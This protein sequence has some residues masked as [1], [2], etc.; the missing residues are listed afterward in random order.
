M[1]ETARAREAWS[2]YVALGPGRS[3]EALLE[4]YRSETGAGRSAPTVRLATLKDWSRHHG[5]QARLREMAEQQERAVREQDAAE[6][7][8]LLST[9]YA[10]KHERVKGLDRL[11]RLVEDEFHEGDRRWLR[12]DTILKVESKEDGTTETL[13]KR[14]ERPNKP[15]ADVYARC[16]DDIA[17][18]MGERS[19]LP[20][21][22][23]MQLLQDRYEQFARAVNEGCAD[24]AG[25][26]ARIL[27]LFFS[28]AEGGADGV[29]LAK[30]DAAGSGEQP[31]GWDDEPEEATP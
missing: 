13:I 12:D 15:W 3:L 20:A 27:A 23:V 30:P 17:R 31:D 6:R 5:W 25:R 18:E 8:R 1:R 16:L 10:A 26:G 22:Y 9:G 11:A 19:N 21:Q 2:D 24:D 4:R 14:K 29:T 7:Q 28:Y